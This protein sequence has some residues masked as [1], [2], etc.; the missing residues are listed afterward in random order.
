LHISRKKSPQLPAESPSDEGAGGF[1]IAM[2]YPAQTTRCASADR[3]AEK[4]GN[5]CEPSITLP[6][7]AHGC[8]DFFA[9]RQTNRFV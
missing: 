3:R 2:I 8:L 6:S 7:I 5:D 4:M 9:L 1:L